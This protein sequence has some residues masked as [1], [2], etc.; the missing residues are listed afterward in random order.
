VWYPSAECIRQW[1]YYRMYRTMAPRKAASF[2]NRSPWSASA[3]SECKK[4]FRCAWA[5]GP[6]SAELC[7]IT[8]LRSR[9]R[10]TLATYSPPRS[11]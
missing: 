7:S 4:Y 11:L 5:Y 10:T 2:P 9:S 6:R 1:S 8:G 3:F